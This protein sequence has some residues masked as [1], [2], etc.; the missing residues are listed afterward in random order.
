[1]TTNESSFFRDVHPY[2][3]LRKVL[4][5]ELITRRA[6]TRRLRIWCA[7]CSSGQASSLAMLLHKHFGSRLEGWEV[8]ILASDLST[9]MLSGPRQE[10]AAARW[11]STGASPPL[12]W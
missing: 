3:A 8:A 11:R 10:G 1:M 7:A 4:I 2:D 9:E 12:C 5:P 6:G